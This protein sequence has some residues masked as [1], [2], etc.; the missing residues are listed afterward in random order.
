[1]FNGQK[2]K[3]VKL[4]RNPL[5]MMCG[6]AKVPAGGIQA[7]QLDNGSLLMNGEKVV[8]WDEIKHLIVKQ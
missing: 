3:P 6:D 5:G 1:M 8:F 2:V 4:L 7:V